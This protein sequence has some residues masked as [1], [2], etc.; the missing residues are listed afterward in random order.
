M[1]AKPVRNWASYSIW[2]PRRLKKK[3]PPPAAVAGQGE[4]PRKLKRFVKNLLVMG[5]AKS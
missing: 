1:G 5:L 2:G 3:S 4:K